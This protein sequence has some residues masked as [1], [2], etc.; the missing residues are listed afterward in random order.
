ICACRSRSRKVEWAWLRP[1]RHGTQQRSYVQRDR[2]PDGFAAEFVLAYDDVVQAVAL[3]Q[4]RL[5]QRDRVAIRSPVQRI[6]STSARIL[7]PPSPW[8]LSVRHLNGRRRRQARP[9]VRGMAEGGSLCNEGRQ[10][11]TKSAPPDRKYEPPILRSA[12]SLLS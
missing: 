6:S 9:Q 4:T 8:M 10:E 1:W 3:K 7:L 11:T 2:A 5:G 12:S